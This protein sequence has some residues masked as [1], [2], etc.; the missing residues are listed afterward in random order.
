MLTAL[1]GQGLQHVAVPRR[2]GEHDETVVIDLLVD[3]KRRY[4]V[5]NVAERVNDALA[6]VGLI[7]PFM[8]YRALTLAVAP[9][10]P[11]APLAT[12][13]VEGVAAALQGA[14]RARMTALGCPEATVMRVQGIGDQVFVT[15]GNDDRAEAANAKAIGWSSRWLA[16]HFPEFTVEEGR[17]PV[18]GLAVWHVDHGTVRRALRLTVS[19]SASRAA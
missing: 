10:S 3:A 17:E 7:A 15:G 9:F 8:S 12:P 14:L 5:A 1:F 2:E 11:E 6:E 13:S 4:D 19:S 18:S 16:K